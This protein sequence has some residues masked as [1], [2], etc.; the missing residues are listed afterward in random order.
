MMRVARMRFSQGCPNCALG[1]D[2]SESHVCPPHD[3]STIARARGFL[4]SKLERNDSD[5]DVEGLIA[6]I[7]T[8]LRESGKTAT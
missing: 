7:A 1:Y 4:R 8:L 2:P 6:A 5:R 3:V